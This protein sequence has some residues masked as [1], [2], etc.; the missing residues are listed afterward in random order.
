M[1]FNFTVVLSML[2]FVA[3]A[4]KP[5][6]QT[7]LSPEFINYFEGTWNGDGEFANGKKI[8]AIISFKVSLDSSWMFYNH[9][10]KLPNHYKATSIWGIDKLTGKFLAYI[11]DNFQGHRLFKAE[12]WLADSLILI[13]KDDSK[14]GIKF[15]Q[16]FQYLKTA[17]G[18]LRMIYE[19]SRDSINWKRGDT[20]L[21]VKQLN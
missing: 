7:K 13:N 15:F 3:T 10:D 12:N 21:F 14:P 5:A 8:C 18:K 17:P 9:T 1:K 19:T 4:Q 20:L 2:F 16:R 6:V 11:F